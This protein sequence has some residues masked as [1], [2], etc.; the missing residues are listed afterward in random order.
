MGIWS[1]GYYFSSNQFT[2]PTWST[3]SWVG[4]GVAVMEREA[5][6]QG[7]AADVQ[8]WGLSSFYGDLLPADIDGGTPPPIGAPGLFF[9]A[10]STI[11]DNIRIWRASIDW[12]NPA[13]ST[14]GLN[15]VDP[16]TTVTVTP[17]V[18]SGDIEQ[19][20]TTNLLDAISPR[21]MFRAP[22]R[23]FGTHESVVLTQTVGNPAAKRWY[24]IRD[25]SADS[26]EL[27]QEGTYTPDDN[28][29]WMGSIAMDGVGNIALGYSV[30][31]S[32]VSPS[33]RVVG[34]NVDDPLGLMST[35]EE[36]IQTGAGHQN[37]YGGRN[38]WGD[39]STMSID[40]ADDCT[41]WYTQEYIAGTGQFIWRT[42]VAAFAF[43]ECEFG[44][45]FVFADGFESGD[46]IAWE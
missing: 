5:M 15:G 35:S 16:N 23:N 33:I 10:H 14:F 37:P 28:G 12:G 44:V 29:R 7:L 31:G 1:D 36:E 20:G 45:G 34:R 30:S 8:Y 19:P 32:E 40:P 2:C 26:P 25:P 46:T 3:C 4:A 42:R 38:R 17:Y 11:V 9:A 24:E 6:I 21:L 22:Y 27:Y 39:Y 41:F 18:A 13:N 43:P